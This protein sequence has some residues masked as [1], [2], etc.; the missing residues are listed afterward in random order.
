MKIFI[1]LENIYENPSSFIKSVLKIKTKLYQYVTYFFLGKQKKN[2][3]LPLIVKNLTCQRE[4]KRILS[5]FSSV[6]QRINFICYIK[7][8]GGAQRQLCQYS[9]LANWRATHCTIEDSLSSWANCL[10]SIIRGKK[11]V[12]WGYWRHVSH[13]SLPEGTVSCESPPG[14]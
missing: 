8:W 9:C 1:S 2:V 5:K 13:C 11:E 6:I 7:E 12:S 4:K 10:L 14:H 3:Y